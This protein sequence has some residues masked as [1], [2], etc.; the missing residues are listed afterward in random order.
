MKVHDEDATG[1]Y[2]SPSTHLTDLVTFLDHLSSTGIR[3]LDLYLRV[4][5]A[6][7]VRNIT[8][9]RNV[10]TLRL[11][12]PV[13]VPETVRCTHM[14]NLEAGGQAGCRM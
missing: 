2:A 6:P 3:E 5:L 12:L 9:L 10:E 4:K 14:Y 1:S 11:K 8:P 7:S 13:L